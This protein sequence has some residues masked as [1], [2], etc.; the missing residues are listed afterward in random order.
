M[1]DDI[2]AAIER[3]VAAGGA[4]KMPKYA[5]DTGFTLAYV[6]DPAGHVISLQQPGA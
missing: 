4:V 3:A 2:D 6:A 1:V 5:T